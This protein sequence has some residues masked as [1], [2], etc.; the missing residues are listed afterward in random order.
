MNGLRGVLINTH[1][2]MK[3][4]PDRRFDW[5]ATFDDYEPGGKWGFIGYGRTEAEA[6]TDL[7]EQEE[8]AP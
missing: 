2:D 5:E 6:V 3:P 4:I 7:L 1:F 8:A